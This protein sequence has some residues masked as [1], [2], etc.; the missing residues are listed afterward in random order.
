M[1]NKKTIIGII[2]VVILIIA[3]IITSYLYNEF[4]TKQIKIFT[5]ET[6]NLL[7]KNIATEE[8]NSEIKTEKNYAIVENAVKEYVSKLKNIYVEID[9]MCSEINPN[10]V[11]SA[12]NL[13]NKEV[14][15]I[16]E[17]IAQYE[18]K[19][20]KNIEEFNKR[21]E[22]E[23]IIKNIEDK[24]IKNRKNYYVDLYKT[25][26]LSDSMKKQYELLESK[27]EHKKDQL[28]DKLQ[29][30]EK[31]KKYLEDNKSYWSIKDGKIQFSNINRMTEYYN[32]VNELLD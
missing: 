20:N 23:Q 5:E 10:D 24:D 31:I 1:E 17:V 25:V 16:D 29:Q 28:K 12:E 3:L 26:M 8:I 2:L 4:N 13:E 18:E 7:Q 6:N 15:K 14:E 32:L 27:I 9:T 19:V 22:E 21:I 30:L 11:F